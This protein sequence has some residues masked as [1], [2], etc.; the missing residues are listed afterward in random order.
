MNILFIADIVGTPGRYM[1]STY[2]PKLKEKY[3]PQVTIVNGENAASGKGITEKIYKQFL[4][5]GVQV[6]TMGNHTWNKKEIV[7]FID[8]ATY[9]I[10]PANLD[11]KSTRLN[12]S[13]VAIS[14]ALFC[15]KKKNINENDDRFQ[16]LS[17]LTLYPSLYMFLWSNLFVLILINLLMF[18]YFDHMFYLY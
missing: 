17:Q 5:L 6:A 7:D 2:L 14:Y 15:L 4:Q 16:V 11:R 12:S 8:D 9:L 10:R 1:L 3:H 13:H 18:L